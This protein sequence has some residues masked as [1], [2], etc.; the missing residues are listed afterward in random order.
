MSVTPTRPST[1]GDL[2]TALADLADNAV[3]HFN[4][5]GPL[6]GDH[7]GRQAIE[8]ALIGTFEPTGGTQKLDIHSIFADD[9]HAFVSLRETAS[10]PDGATLDVE[11]AHV[12]TINPG[13]DH[14]SVGPAVRP[15]GARPVL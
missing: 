3:F 14:E 9:Q 6:S 11:E 1:R 15:A 4:G 2:D 10:R 8:K 13:A 12:L 5:E 7:T